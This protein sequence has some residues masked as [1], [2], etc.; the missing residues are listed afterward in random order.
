MTN[1]LSPRDLAR[2]MVTVA[3]R[4]Y[5]PLSFIARLPFAMMLVGILSLT[6]IERGS[7]ALAGG[8]TAVAG[9]GTALMGPVFG[10]LADRWGQRPVLLGGAL[11]SIAASIAFLTAVSDGASDAALWLSAAAVGATM[12]QVAPLSRSR[13]AVVAQR[14]EHHSPDARGRALPLA[15]SYESIVDESS[16]VL[17]PVAVGLLASLLA[18]TAPLV[19]SMVLTATV[20]IAFALHPTARLGT[21]RPVHELDVMARRPSTWSAELSLLAVAMLAVGA[22]FGSTLTSVTAYL[23]ALGQTELAGLVYGIMSIGAII[24]A[25]AVG[26]LP[27]TISLRSRWRWFACVAVAGTAVLALVPGDGAVLVGLFVAGC[28][29]GAVLVALFSL[30]ANAAHERRRNTVLVTLQ[31]MLTVGQAL[32]TALTGVLVEQS[33]AAA[34]F[35]VAVGASV[36]LLV[37]AL[38]HGLVASNP[39]ATESMNSG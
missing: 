28:G 8:L 25:L 27:P 38:A 14:L 18:P 33:G 2:Q 26:L 12:P 29:V 36:A 23:A 39:S 37:M 7:L 20:V 30:G 15:M 34:G 6:T 31:S 11:I 13:A 1:A 32:V 21:A 24:T 5:L 9:I 35:A 4:P 17:G 16:Y 19:A 3:G 22:V 10:A